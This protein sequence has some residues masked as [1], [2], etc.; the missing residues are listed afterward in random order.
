MTEPT[1]T[2]AEQAQGSQQPGTGDNWKARYDGL[3][4]KVQQLTLEGRN[5]DAQLAQQS[6]ETEQLRAQLGLK[7]TE[8][9]VAIAERDNKVREVL[10]RQSQ[11]DTELSELRAFRL[12]AKVATDIGHPELVGIFNSIPNLT[13]EGALKAVFADFTGFADKAVARRV[14]YQE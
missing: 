8:K 1:E 14:A 10:T 7:D 13:D 5:K 3:V 4:L 12:K 6:S 11:T 9:Q 2:P